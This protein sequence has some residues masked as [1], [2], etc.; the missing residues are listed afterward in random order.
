[1]KNSQ[2]VAA[3]LARGRTLCSLW[4]V[5]IARD[6]RAGKRGRQRASHYQ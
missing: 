6:V 1:M 2:R 5:G 3:S 4:I